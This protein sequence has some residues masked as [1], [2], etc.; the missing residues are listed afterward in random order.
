MHFYKWDAHS[1]QCVTYCDTGVSKCS[2]I[3]QNKIDRFIPG[4]MNTFDQLMLGIALQAEQMM[5]SALGMLAQCLHY[6]LKRGD[7]IDPWLSGAEKIQIG[8]IEYQNA[9]HYYWSTGS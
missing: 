9:R 5:A 4:P 2:R 3:D 6:V 7:A 1:Q 8:A